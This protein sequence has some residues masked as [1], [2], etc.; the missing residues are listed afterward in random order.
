MLSI[1]KEADKYY[2]IRDKKQIGDRKQETKRNSEIGKK[3]L[4]KDLGLIM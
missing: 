4:G 3:G 2:W 1:S